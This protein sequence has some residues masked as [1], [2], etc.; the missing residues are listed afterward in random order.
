MLV[1][2]RG[3]N[4]VRTKG[5]T[6][7]YHRR[8][9]TRL[10]SEPGTP[11]FVQEVAVLDGMP[12]A[13]GAPRAGSLGGLI[14]AYKGSPEFAGLAEQTRRD[15]HRVFD[16]LR[17][18]D[19]M[20]LM[21]LATS[22][23]VGMRDKAFEQHK[24]RF[25]NYVIAVASLLFAWG[26]IRGWLQSNPAEGVPKIRRPKNLPPANRPWT[27]VEFQTVFKAG[28]TEMRAPL[29]LGLFLREGDVV[30]APWSAYDGTALNS[31]QGK[32]GRTVWT[33]LPKF[34]RTVLDAAPRKSPVIVLGKRGRPYQTVSGF[35]SQFFKLLRELQ[36]SGT[37]A[38]GLTFHGLRHSM[39]TWLA[40][41]EVDIRGIQ[42]ILG[43]E[44][45]AMA[46]H[47]SKGADTRR[48]AVAAIEKLERKKIKLAKPIAKPCK[49][50]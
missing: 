3:L 31:R 18:I 14:A 36:G 26:K 2:L 49:S 16:W 42:S 10:R 25:A 33:P 35:R 1:K 30:R 8:T 32:T 11:E 34:V 20:P 17:S 23:I 39:G 43:H 21:E 6:Y 24:R 37:I 13:H 7:Y 12:R 19:E 15:Y 48:A 22:F 45:P 29:V 9:G 47:Y 27:V 44:T 28:P 40:D 5:R 38:K 50:S 4:K 46:G 41:E